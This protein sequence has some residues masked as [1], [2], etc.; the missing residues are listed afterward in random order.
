MMYTSQ[1]AMFFCTDY[2]VPSQDDDD[3]DGI[4]AVA[5]VV[6]NKQNIAWDLHCSFPSSLNVF[7]LLLHKFI[8]A[9]DVPS[10]NGINKLA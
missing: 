9:R 5:V 4:V 2:G 10:K 1:T 7:V 8:R 3:E 6:E